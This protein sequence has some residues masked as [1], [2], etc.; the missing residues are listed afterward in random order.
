MGNSR[1]LFSGMP[2]ALAD[3]W[4]ASKLNSV[5]ISF[6]RQM[7]GKHDSRKK[8]EKG[9]KKD[10]RRKSPDSRSHPLRTS[11]P[12]RSPARTVTKAQVHS[13]PSQSKQQKRGESSSRKKSGKK[14][15]QSTEESHGID[16]PSLLYDVIRRVEQQEDHESILKDMPLDNDAWCDSVVLRQAKLLKLTLTSEHLRALGLRKRQLTDDKEEEAG[17]M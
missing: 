6:Q 12:K 8:L 4:F 2:Y 17:K 11:S 10:S 13:T 3:D 15:K 14:G 1:G 5:S 9:E 16:I 7:M